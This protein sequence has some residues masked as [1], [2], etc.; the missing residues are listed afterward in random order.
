MTDHI[1]LQSVPSIAAAQPSVENAHVA[2]RLA[3]KRMLAGLVGKGVDSQAQPSVSTRPYGNAEALASNDVEVMT[4]QAFAQQQA[5]V[6]GAIFGHRLNRKQIADLFKQLIVDDDVVLHYTLS[7]IIR[8]DDFNQRDESDGYRDESEAQ[9]NLRYF[10]AEQYALAASSESVLS[11]DSEQF[12]KI[13]GAMSMRLQADPVD[14]QAKITAALM[15]TEVGSRLNMSPRNFA[16]IYSKMLTDI[17]RMSPLVDQVVKMDSKRITENIHVLIQVLQSAFKRDRKLSR[18]FSNPI[19]INQ[20]LSQ[21]EVLADIGK[22]NHAARKSKE[23]LR[24][25]GADRLPADAHELAA[26]CRLIDQEDSPSSSPVRDFARSIS[27]PKMRAVYLTMTTNALRQVSP[28]R[29]KENSSRLLVLTEMM[30]LAQQAYVH[31]GSF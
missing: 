30:G 22:L 29:W 19:L 28:S 24:K 12:A 13:E 21:I 20:F 25:K 6:A 5:G 4:H 9:R 1:H 8:N 27:K 11:L 18:Q 3:A 7:K 17:N 16:A 10:L 15:A 31:S 2:Q 26:A 23:L 14:L